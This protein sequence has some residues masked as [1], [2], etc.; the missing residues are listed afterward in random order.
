MVIGKK[1][2]R[3]SVARHRIKRILREQFRLN[4]DLFSGLD[5]V[6]VARTGLDNLSNAEMADALMKLIH[7]VQ[8]QKNRQ[9][10]A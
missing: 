6:L 10:S 9:A 7:A 2:V 1:H 3:L 8:R 4:R 5:V